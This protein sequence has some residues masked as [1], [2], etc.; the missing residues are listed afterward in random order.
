M[1]AYL[2]TGNPAN[3]RDCSGSGT[4][5]ES[6]FNVVEMKIIFLL[7]FLA[8][9]SP[10]PEPKMETVHFRPLDEIVNP[11]KPSEFTRLVDRNGIVYLFR[12]HM[13]DVIVGET[14][15]CYVNVLGIGQIHLLIS[16][17]EAA[18]LVNQ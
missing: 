2:D 9:C 6:G 17:D 8:G 3:S 18:E 4:V 15:G 16:P 5:G 14:N 12:K 10:S 11:R 1:E 13:I 7:I